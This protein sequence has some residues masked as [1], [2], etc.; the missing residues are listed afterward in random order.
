M[1]R[2][3]L[4]ALSL[5]TLLVLTIFAAISSFRRVAPSAPATP[6]AITSLADNHTVAP[7]QS[8]A[9]AVDTANPDLRRFVT[10]ESAS[11]GE[12]SDRVTPDISARIPSVS[13]PSEI[14]AIFYVLRDH[15]D[16][17]TERNEAMNLLRRSQVPLDDDVIML[18]DRPYEAPRI[19]SF[20]AQHLGVGLTSAS[21]AERDRIR[22]R[23]A[24]ALD[25]RDLAVRRE[26]LGALATTEDSAA[27]A[28]LESGID[29]PQNAGMQDLVIR[30][31]HRA[32]R[33]SAIPAIRTHL[34]DP[35]LPTR[36]AAIYV[37]GQWKDADSQPAFERAVKDPQRAVR[38]AGAMA[39][40]TMKT[41]K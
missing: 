41:A 37:L 1:S 23:L 30:L 7:P 28:R 9:P 31:L 40:T 32:D 21:G 19:R 26:A 17:D 25:D 10:K 5:V 18:L 16:G 20:F 35:S 29:A 6:S 3:R 2:R 14:D 36:I 11:E 24:S 4:I 27:K 15:T 22:S 38:D 33:R 12:H 13:R 8:P 34:D 39:L